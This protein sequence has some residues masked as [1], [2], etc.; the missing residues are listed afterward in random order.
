MGSTYLN[1]DGLPVTRV[2]VVEGDINIDQLDLVNDPENPLYVKNINTAEEP[3]PVKLTGSN[4]GDPLSV[5][6]ENNSYVDEVKDVNKPITLTRTV[7][8]LQPY[9]PRVRPTLFFPGAERRLKWMDSE[10][11]LY[12]VESGNKLQKSENY[13]ESWSTIYTIDTEIHG[14]AAASAVFVT[15]SGKVVLATQKGYVFVSDSDQNNFT[16]K[17]QFTR[18]FT[19]DQFGYGTYENLVW[20]A[21]YGSNA[22]EGN[23]ANELYLSKDEGETF[24]KVF[25]GV[26]LDSSNNWHIH[27][28]QYDPY[29]DRF[30][31]VNGDANNCQT[32]YSDD[33]GQTW[34][35]VFGDF[36]DDPLNSQLT[37][38]AC[39][40]HG[41][42]FGGDHAS[43][44]DDD[45]GDILRY[46]PRPKGVVRPFVD[47]NTIVEIYRLEKDNLFR[48]FAQR[49]YQV[50]IDGRIISLMPW[51]GQ[52]APAVLLAS[53][54]GLDW[55]EIYRSDLFVGGDK[56]HI[57]GVDPKDPERRIFGTVGLG[58]GRTRQF[59]APL[60]E[61]ILEF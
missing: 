56:F 45:Y 34:T 13:G 50:R 20:L 46:W 54:N 40:P 44:G 26:V 28:V 10:G 31:I 4:V 53:A 48:N 18:H 42:V 12:G 11:H 19:N 3:I 36:A 6:L 5:S 55:Y 49:T 2:G 25:E 43:P 33:L 52:N 41:V 51:Y 14:Q 7:A 8:P 57:A 24:E 58:D 39:Y 47:K 9:P 30:W 27:D 1:K 16:E 22:K 60:P 35:P 29:S 59:V 38:I 32:W 37:S 23:H 21:N 17:F 15:K 61:F